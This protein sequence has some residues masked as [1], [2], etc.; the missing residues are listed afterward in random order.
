MGG[1]PV[2]L[3]PVALFARPFTFKHF[4]RE[5]RLLQAHGDLIDEHAQDHAN[6]VGEKALER[7]TCS[8]TFP[9]PVA[10]VQLVNAA[11]AEE[12]FVSFHGGLRRLAVEFQSG[13][14]GCAALCFAAS[15]GVP[16][17]LILSEIC[18][19]IAEIDLVEVGVVCEAVDERSVVLPVGGAVFTYDTAATILFCGVSFALSSLLH[20]EAA[21]FEQASGDLA[22]DLF[23]VRKVKAEL[24]KSHGVDISSDAGIATD[25]VPDLIVVQFVEQVLIGESGIRPHDDSALR[26]T[27]LE[28]LNQFVG[29]KQEQLGSVGGS[30]RVLHEGGNLVDRDHDG[31]IAR[32]PVMTVVGTL[33]LRAVQGDGR[34][35]DVNNQYVAIVFF[36]DVQGM[37]QRQLV[38]RVDK[39]RADT[40]GV[41]LLKK[42]GLFPLESL[43]AFFRSDFTELGKETRER[44][45]GREMS[46]FQA[47]A[48]EGIV[49]EFLRIIE[50]FAP[51]EPRHDKLFKKVVIRVSIGKERTRTDGV[52][53]RGN[54]SKNVAVSQNAN[55][56]FYANEGGNR[57]SVVDVLNAVRNFDNI[58]H[59]DVLVCGFGRLAF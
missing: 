22:G 35:V 30:R 20:N 51:K 10:V 4:L 29:V 50:I 16:D 12:S 44:G 41:R 15:T 36:N 43:I 23:K 31:K 5:D 58:R 13:V 2:A 34:A 17:Q 54:R 48:R 1:R 46:S 18:L 9:F 53:E 55:E 6:R 3:L 14:N 40:F 38:E 28:R 8:G 27:L 57:F 24:L 42:V 33:F 52:E 56:F 37:L 59:A 32:H 49:V 47:G 11:V 7:T 21:F 45:R 19:D 26:K 25:D 39:R